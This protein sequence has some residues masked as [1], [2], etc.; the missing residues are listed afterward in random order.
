MNE[1]VR[2]VEECS[3]PNSIRSFLQNFSNLVS[4][5]EL[6]NFLHPPESHRLVYGETIF[7][8]R[9]TLVGPLSAD[10]EPQTYQC[11]SQTSAVVDTCA[12]ILHGTENVKI[13]LSSAGSVLKVPMTCPVS[14]ERK[15]KISSSKGLS[16]SQGSRLEGGG[17][18]IAEDDGR[19]SLETG[20]W[21]SYFY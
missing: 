17:K 7:D 3:E 21:A 15:E 4:S 11:P 20:A 5:S 6:G 2:S 16:A 10:S 12:F 14:A 18:G 9:W 19:G 13:K 8:E 1:G